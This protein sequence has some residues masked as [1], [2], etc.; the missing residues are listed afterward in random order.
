MVAQTNN[1]GRQFRI[2]YS[3]GNFLLKGRLKM[4]DTKSKKNKHMTL[5]DRQEIMEYL[6]KGMTF[7]AIAQRIGKDPTTVSKEVKKHIVVR[8]TKVRSKSLDG[9]P[10][11]ERRCPSLLKAPFVCN[12]CK[13]RRSDC[14]FQ[15]QL[16]IAKHAHSEYETLLC[17]AREG[18]PLNKEE[19]WEADTIIS[20][21][22]KKGQRLYHI[23]DSN[24]VGFSKSTA[25]RH[26]H[27]GYLSVS[28]LEFPR[29]VKFKARKQPQADSVPKGVRIGRTYDDFKA[30]IEEG[31]IKSWVEMD[32]VIGRVG[33][34]VIMT[35]HFTFCNF[36]FGLLLDDRTAAE[37]ALRI[38]ELKRLL[39]DGKIRFGDIIPLL[40]TDNG[41]E[42]SNVFAF[43]D[44]LDGAAETNLFFCDPYRACQKPRVEKNHTMFR[45]IVPKGES[46]D[47]FTQD[48]VNLIFSHVNGVK[49][50]IFNGRTPYE[51]FSFTFGENVASLLGIHE[52]PAAE[53]I[54]SPMLLKSLPSAVPDLK[55]QAGTITAVRSEGRVLLNA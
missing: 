49:R 27:R 55:L 34:K 20:E 44:D 2:K 45:D 13:R 4:P 12:P 41:G 9:I 48:D 8:E 40:L 54:Q 16:Y 29:V 14:S 25:Y 39:K 21:G 32:T 28:K 5:D 11:E 22:I 24:D 43:T 52:V 1:Y 7:K 51:V 31:N 42:F 30:F 38:R 19:F 17:E 6:D 3:L 18:I 47:R 37:A 33:G 53:V 46:F 10:I 15:K 35:F 26:L 23:M 36:M 50:K